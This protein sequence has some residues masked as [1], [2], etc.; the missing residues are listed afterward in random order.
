MVLPLIGKLGLGILKSIVSGRK[1]GET[2]KVT[3]IISTSQERKQFSDDTKRKETFVSN[4]FKQE[5]SSAIVKTTSP[6]TS[7]AQSLNNIDMAVSNIQSTVLEKFKLEKKQFA[8]TIKKQNL[9]RKRFF[10]RKMET[11][12]S[13]P[14]NLM[15]GIKKAGGSII[16]NMLVFVTSLIL[17]TIV[18]VLFQSFKRIAEF[19]KGIVFAINNFFEKLDPF[20]TPI[21]NFFNIFTKESKDINLSTE[22][23]D[24]EKNAA[25]KIEKKLKEFEA[26]QNKIIKQLEKEQ[27]RLASIRMKMNENTI[28]LDGS[29]NVPGLSETIK[30]REGDDVGAA[31]AGSNLQNKNIIDEDNLSFNLPK[32][33]TKTREEAP[34]NL[35]SN[36]LKSEGSNFSLDKLSINSPQIASTNLKG[37][38]IGSPSGS[39]SSPP[40]LPPLPKNIPNVQPQ[41]PMF[42]SKFKII[43]SYTPE[44][45][46]GYGLDGVTDY[47]GRPLVF[48]RPAAQGFA[49][50]MEASKGAISGDDIAST[51]RSRSKNKEVGGDPN[52]SHMTGEA[53]DLSGSSAE[54]LKKNGEKYGWYY[55]YE[56]PPVGSGSFHFNYMPGGKYGPHPGLLLESGPP[57]AMGIDSQTSYEKNGVRTVMMSP[58]KSKSDGGSMPG[59]VALIPIP[60]SKKDVLN[61]IVEENLLASLYKV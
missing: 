32:E 15:R 18:L 51:G 23:L 30:I 54:W 52:S 19:F 13:G 31:A 50:A 45:G 27:S 22:G 8:K 55:G 46:G 59:D 58:P 56:H 6:P 37:L 2:K 26:Q 33:P 36:T 57:Q 34:K 12:K 38:G 14:S 24:E 44:T 28:G 49:S 9:L 17:G 11:L 1:S 10:E 42:G 20:I 41:T 39:L 3:Q 48:S 29:I 7:I 43:P 25:D 61:S 60:P 47:L 21:F 40:P 16:D 35:S 5:Q 4:F 53:I